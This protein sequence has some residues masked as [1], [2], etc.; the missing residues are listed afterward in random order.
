[1]D[2]GLLP[3]LQTVLQWIVAPVVAVV[4]MMYRQQQS[5]TTD[6]AV[7]KA[8]LLSAKAAHDREMKE[9]RETTRAIMQKLDSIE[10]A[11][12]K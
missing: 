5:H 2:S 10:Q 8:D 9:I 6:I 12:R 4:W 11:L 7:I 1:M 3:F